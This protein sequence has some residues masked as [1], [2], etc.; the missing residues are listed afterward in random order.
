MKKYLA[1]DIGGSKL[2]VGVVDE[3]GGIEDVKRMDFT[4]RPT[5][6]AIINGIA[7]LCSRLD[8][9]DAAAG[10]TTVPGLTDPKNGVWLSSPYLG[11][12]SWRI[13][14]E[15]GE[16][17]GI[18]FYA[19]NDVR[20]CAVGEKEFGLCGGI[21]DF[22]W[23]TMSNGVGGALYLDGRL[24][25][26]ARFGAGEIGHIAVEEN[27]EACG[28]GN[29]GCLETAASGRGISEFYRKLTGNS[30]SAKEI[31]ALAEKNDAAAKK[32]YERAGKALGKAVSYAVNL[33][34]LDTF[35]VGGGVAQSYNLFFTARDGGNR[36]KGIEIGEPRALI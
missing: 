36:R 35:V 14:D 13:A 12:D 28:C 8:Y 22:M 27:G 7:G 24:Y 10:G 21:G 20:A 3:N 23:I 30:F 33:L 19:E 5:K 32:A 9:S 16:K 31:A 6:E 26:G 15:L 29:R 17:F 34:N 1:V 18:P 2:L 25:E 11:I 4:A